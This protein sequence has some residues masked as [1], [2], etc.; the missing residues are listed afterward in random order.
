MRCKLLRLSA[1][2]R[3]W[4]E[5]NFNKIV[6]TAAGIEPFHVPFGGTTAPHGSL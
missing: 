3:N 6:F 1:T 4:F 5:E 2:N